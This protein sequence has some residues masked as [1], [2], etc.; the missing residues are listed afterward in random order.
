MASLGK[1]QS[2]EKNFC[3]G[4]WVEATKEGPK[5]GKGNPNFSLRLERGKQI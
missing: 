2:K 4:E 1:K 3:K 5:G